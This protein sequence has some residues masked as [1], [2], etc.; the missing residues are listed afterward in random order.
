[1]NYR[2]DEYREIFNLIKASL[3][4]SVCGET[5]LPAP[6]IVAVAR[7]S[8]GEA[9]AGEDYSEEPGPERPRPIRGAPKS[10]PQMI[11]YDPATACTSTQYK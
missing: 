3:P 11:G 1:M 2:R 10:L 9:D 5:A 8:R 7:N 6:G 4:Y